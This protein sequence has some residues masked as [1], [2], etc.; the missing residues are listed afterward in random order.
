MGTRPP[1]TTKSYD[2]ASSTIQL[3]TTTLQSKAPTTTSATHLTTQTQSKTTNANVDVSSTQ[4]L[5]STEPSN[6]TQTQKWCTIT[7]RNTTLI[8]TSIDLQHQLIQPLHYKRSY[9]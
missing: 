7:S 1:F 9:T 5:T 2:I 6:I 4:P 8:E 3:L